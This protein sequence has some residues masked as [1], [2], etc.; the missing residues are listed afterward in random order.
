MPADPATDEQPKHPISRLTT[1]ELRD[2]RRS[3]ERA[4]AFFGKQDPVPPARDHLQSAL[5]KVLAEQEERARVAA[6]A[7]ASL[8]A[9]H[10]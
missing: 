7:R 8:T 4:I 6:R 5:D 2:Y 10:T 1:Y 9:T 3:L